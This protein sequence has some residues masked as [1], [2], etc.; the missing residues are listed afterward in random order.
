MARGPVR[1]FFIALLSG[2]L[3]ACGGSGSPGGA[4]SGSPRV[5]TPTA[6]PTTPA[7][8]TCPKGTDP[9]AVGPAKQTRP[10]F[11]EE[12]SASAAFDR[13][14]GRVVYVD[15]SGQTWTFDVCTN[16]WDRVATRGERPSG[17]DHLFYD[18]HDD[19]T[20]ALGGSLPTI[21]T[22]DVETST[23]TAVAHPD[24]SW[25][26]DD[27][28][29]MDPDNRVIYGYLLGADM[30]AYDIARNTWT[31]VDQ[32]A[33]RPPTD[34]WGALTTVDPSVGRVMLY[35]LRSNDPVTAPP[36]EPPVQSNVAAETWTFDLGTR[37]WTRVATATPLL[38]FGW[39]VRGTEMSYNEASRSTVIFADG[40][41]AVFDTTTNQ[42]TQP[43]PGKGW[44]DAL[45]TGPLARLGPGLVD[46][47]VNGRVLVFGG[48]IRTPDEERQWQDGSDVWAYDVDANAWTELVPLDLGKG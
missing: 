23:W 4:D 38:N 10:Q 8:A 30:W 12:S 7:T 40:T 32:G 47:T 41:V 5:T 37:S 1:L 14:S 24:R 20:Y 2:V 44:P 45:E 27:Q 31:K 17:S 21:R 18:A 6:V 26:G 43:Q 25:A 19:L 28:F 9:N 13:Q 11:G 36:T 42:W 34:W 35:G 16:T 46:D 39:Y 15:S 22:F 48:S 3:A 29:V 33:L